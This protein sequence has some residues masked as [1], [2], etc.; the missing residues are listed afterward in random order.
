MVCLMILMSS[1]GKNVMI[2]EDDAV[3]R[4]GLRRFFINE[5][6]SSLDFG[7]GEEAFA[8]LEAS[9]PDL[10]FC[11]YK[12]PGANGLEIMRQIRESGIKSP[13]VMMSAYCSDEL[14]IKALE[15]GAVAVLE[16]P[17]DLEELRKFC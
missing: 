13:F 14:K 15:N 1:H 16:K 4:R 9:P 5:G 10:I 6:F 12:L 3:L 7:T 8:S 11:D 2:I 17:F